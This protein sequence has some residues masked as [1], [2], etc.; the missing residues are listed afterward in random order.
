[1]QVH[2]LLEFQ[3]VYLI[4]KTDQAVVRTVWLVKFREQSLSRL[5]YL[6]NSQNIPTTAAKPSVNSSVRR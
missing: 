5:S 2:G 4:M 1:M 3:H 6:I